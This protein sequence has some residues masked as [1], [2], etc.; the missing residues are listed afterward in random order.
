MRAAFNLFARDERDLVV[1]IGEQQSL[2]LSRALRIDALA[3]EKWRAVLLERGRRHR[4]CRELQRF[5][6]GHAAALPRDVC[7]ECCDVCGRRATTAA[8]GVDA[9]IVHE[10]AEFDCHFTRS[11]GIDRLALWAHQWKARIGDHADETARV[12][13]EIA[14]GVA[15]VRR[16]SR[17]I[18]TDHVDRERIERCRHRADIGAKEHASRDVERRLRLNRHALDAGC[19]GARDAGDRRLHL[20]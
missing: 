5:G 18:E 17:A 14:H 11:F 2:D 6:L 16:A 15:H 1:V 12:V 10:R 13:D 8:D 19:K 3:D 7:N 4:R 9:E 20:E